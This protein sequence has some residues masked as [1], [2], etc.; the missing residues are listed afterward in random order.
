MPYPPV[1]K[2]RPNKRRVRTSASAT[3]DSSHAPDA[4][5]SRLAFG[6]RGAL[7]WGE[8]GGISMRK[9]ESFAHACRGPTGS[10]IQ[11]RRVNPWIPANGGVVF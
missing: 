7:L 3:E 2:S 9:G 10:R 6:A 4:I 5:L 11:G 1:K 8:Y